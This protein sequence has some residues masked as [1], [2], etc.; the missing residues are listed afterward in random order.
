MIYPVIVVIVD[1]IKYRALLDT[2]AGSSYASA[3]LVKRLGK[4]PNRKELKRID[5][6]FSTTQKIEQ[7]EVKISSVRGKF[8]M[9]TTVSQ[10]D[11]GV[12][13]SNPNPG[14]AEKIN[15]YPH[16]KGVVMDDEDT[17]PEHWEYVSTPG[18]KPTQNQGLEKLG[19][20]SQS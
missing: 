13:P 16:L 1:G 10:G 17:K 2:G 11:K 15:K 18:L 4:Q 3:A 14:Y 19:S 8:E 20:R 9:T 7:Y 6:M 12:L 5:M